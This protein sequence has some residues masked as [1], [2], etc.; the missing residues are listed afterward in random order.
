MVSLPGILGGR[1][2]EAARRSEDN[3]DNSGFELKNVNTTQRRSTDT[4]RSDSSFVSTGLTRSAPART[5][6]QTRNSTS[7]S[8]A[9]LHTLNSNSNAKSA[10]TAP[11][12]D[13]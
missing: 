12:D 4:T 10:A 9:S 2:S 7:S 6:R 5:E 8:S 1:A 11:A 13:G 3:Q